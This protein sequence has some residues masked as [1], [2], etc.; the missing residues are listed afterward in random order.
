MTVE[1]RPFD[2]VTR[3]GVRIHG[4]ESGPADGRPIVFNT[5]WT[6][7]W[8]SFINQLTDPELASRF[9]MIAFDLRGHG[10]SDAPKDKAMYTPDKWGEELKDV[11]DQRDV[12]E[13]V[14]LGWS[15]GGYVVCDYLRIYGEQGIAGAV[16]CD[17]AVMLGATERERALAGQGFERWYTDSCSEDQLTAFTAIK[18][19]VRECSYHELP[20]EIFD[21]ALCFNAVVPPYVRFFTVDRPT[22][23]NTELL[24][25]LTIPVLVNQGENDTITKPAAAH[26]ILKHC[27]TAKAHFYPECGHMP[28]LEYSKQFNENL[29]AFAGNI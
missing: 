18:G 13:P 4:R 25:G 29:A 3:D 11:L 15:F 16:F 23:D 28:F 20:K 8:M 14:L 17:W 27:P 10:A 21:L 12:V 22:L 19:F 24:S 26:H 1:L 2:I 6:Q 7:S 5:G 9:R